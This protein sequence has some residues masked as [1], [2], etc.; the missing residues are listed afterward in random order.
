MRAAGDLG[1]VDRLLRLKDDDLKLLARITQHWLRHKFATEA[2]RKD[3]KAAMAQGG[4]RDSRSTAK[5]LLRVTLVVIT[6]TSPRVKPVS[7]RARYEISR[8]HSSL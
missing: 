4:W 8:T 7:G 5:T 6:R 2:G 3:M 1:E